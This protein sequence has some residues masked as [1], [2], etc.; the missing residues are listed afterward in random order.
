MCANRRDLDDEVKPL[1]TKI[2]PIR[3]A[4][5]VLRLSTPST[6]VLY[7][8]IKRLLDIVIAT[9][10]LV[11]LSPLMALIALAIVL[12]S[13]GPVIFRQKRVLGGQALE[14]GH[15]PAERVFDF[16]KFRSMVHKADESI[17]RQYM[18]QLIN[19]NGKPT[20]SAGKALYKLDRDPRVTRVGR[21]LRKT[22]LDELPQ[23]YNVLKGEM[24]LVGPRPALPYEVRQY[25]PWYMQRLT[26]Q[27][28]LTGLWQVMGRNE[29]SFE[30]MIALDL[31]YVRR[32]SLIL[33]LKILLAT[34]PAVLSCRGVS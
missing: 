22:S 9:T 7:P 12:D 26:V 31:E 28:G 8:L 16:Y 5:G 10:L 18:E 20:L 29:L 15:D 6:S 17:H 3:A 1:A 27:Q 14:D 19:G 34:V 30:E 24:T 11:L 21:F 25:K 2:A 32:R 33:D 23:L 4:T 13:P